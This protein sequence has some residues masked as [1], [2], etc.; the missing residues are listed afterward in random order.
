MFNE[1]KITKS[2]ENTN[3]PANFTSNIC[4]NLKQNPP[5]SEYIFISFIKTK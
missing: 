2:Q 5:L 1:C 4:A 3:V